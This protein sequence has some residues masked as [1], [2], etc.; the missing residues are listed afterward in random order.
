MPVS[1]IYRSTHTIPCLNSET[2]ILKRSTSH[3]LIQEGSQPPGFQQRIQGKQQ[4]QIPLIT[5]INLFP[6]SING[7]GSFHKD[8]LGQATKPG[9]TQ[10]S[11]LS[12]PG[13]TPS[14]TLPV[15]QGS[16]QPR[17]PGSDIQGVGRADPCTWMWDFIPKSRGKRPLL[18]LKH[19]DKATPS[20]LIP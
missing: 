4:Y 6:H 15:S 9:L 3:H 20:F 18:L 16:S 19:S 1:H 10:S 17:T 13:S 5:A 7:G 11:A 14:L 2:T 8:L 12:K